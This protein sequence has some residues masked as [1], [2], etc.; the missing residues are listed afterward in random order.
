MSITTDVTHQGALPPQSNQ[1]S[2]PQNRLNSQTQAFR[3]AETGTLIAELKW[4]PEEDRYYK[5]TGDAWLMYFNNENENEW[6]TAWDP[7]SGGD[8]LLVADF[9]GDG[10]ITSSKE[11]MGTEDHLGKTVFNNGYEKM[12][13]C[14]DTNGDGKVNGAELE[15]LQIWEDRDGDGVTDEGELVSLDTHGIFEFSLDFTE[16]DMES[17]YRKR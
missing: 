8:G 9:D 2:P 3:N 14:F 15:G 10:K 16:E 17:S 6:T 13:H 1:T 4:S 11:L 7:E 12:A 5:S